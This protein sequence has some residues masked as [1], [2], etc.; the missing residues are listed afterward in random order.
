M[1]TW[2]RSVEPNRCTACICRLLPF[3]DVGIR[4][5]ASSVEGKVEGKYQVRDGTY[6]PSI[7]RCKLVFLPPWA[8]SRDFPIRILMKLDERDRVHLYRIGIRSMGYTHTHVP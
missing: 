5:R 4:D 1:Q 6:G 7:V 2:L 8:L 3:E